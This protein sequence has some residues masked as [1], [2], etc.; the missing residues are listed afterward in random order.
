MPK[1]T[2]ITVNAGRTFNHPHESYSNLRPSV[3]VK[4]D[5]L[6][7]EDWQAVA[8]ELQAKAE[9]MIEDHKRNML[10]SLEELYDLTTKQREVA[11]LETRIASAQSRLDRIRKETPALQ[12]G[13]DLPDHDEEDDED[14][15]RDED[16]E[17]A[18]RERDRG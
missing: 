12:L 5:V 4:A 7:G 3:T 6:D 15:E 16:P 10:Q 11:D 17:W 13:L 9:S 18:L 8:K 2:E 14:Y 1:I